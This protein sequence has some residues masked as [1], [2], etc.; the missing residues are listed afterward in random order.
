MSFLKNILSNLFRA[1]PVNNIEDIKTACVFLGP[2]RNLTT[3]T[4][5]VLALH[6]R[7]QMLNHAGGR[8][9]SESELN[10]IENHSLEK[11]YLK[12]KERILIPLPIIKCAKI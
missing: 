3:L 6:P 2:Y 12:F 10:F 4:A 5:S 11:V 8:I 7:C 9:F 1:A